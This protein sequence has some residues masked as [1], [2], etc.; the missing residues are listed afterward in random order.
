MSTPTQDS[1]H[2]VFPEAAA[3]KSPGVRQR[4]ANFILT[5]PLGS[6]GLLIMV[7]MIAAAVLANI[8]A[9]Y[10]PYKMN[11]TKRLKPPSTT[12]VLGTDNFGRDMFSRIIYGARISLYIGLVATA[13]GTG[14][15]AVFGLASGYWGGKLDLVLQRFMD[16]MLSI[17]GLVLA[18]AIVAV[19]GSSI[20]NVI[21]AIAIPVIPRACR[22][23]RGST[24]IVRAMD[25]IQAARTI[26][27]ADLR[28]ILW[29]V[30]PNIMA[31]YLIL[32]TAQL[33]NSILVEASLSF[34]GLGTPEPEP[35]WGLMLSGSAARFAEAAP[36]VAIFPGLAISLAVLG[37]N[38]FGDALRD[39][40]DPRLRGA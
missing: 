15:G 9:P 30:L 1:L 33:G 16:I 31:P 6:A 27:C 39:A 3:R 10:D 26:G 21:L 25:Y 17:P 8:I 32:V 36:W 13:I 4:L 35:S 2:V 38:L 18:L 23:A 12:F 24:L 22:I 19:L 37:F 40:W 5:K 20:N 34:L 28:I 7:V 29:H 11:P 14:V